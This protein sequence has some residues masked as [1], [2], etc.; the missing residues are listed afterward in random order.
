MVQPSRTGRERVG[1]IDAVESELP[2]IS[3]LFLRSL[4][5]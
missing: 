5:H 2:S 1:L 4:C 3:I